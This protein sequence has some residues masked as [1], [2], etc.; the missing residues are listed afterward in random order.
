MFFHQIKPVVFPHSQPFLTHGIGQPGIYFHFMKKINLLFFLLTPVCLPAQNRFDVVIHEIMADPSPAVGLPG[1]EWV[2]LRNRSAF[3]VNLQNWRL[4]DASTLSGPMPVFSLQPDSLVIVCTASAVTAMN[5]YGRTLSVTG[6]PSLDNTGDL[7]YLRAPDGR[8]IHA[9]QYYSDWYHHDIKKDGGWTLEM[10]DP[11]NP[12]S[13]GSNWGASINPAGGTPGKYNSIQA[14]NPD[15]YA[16]KLKSAYAHDSLTILLVF[17]EPLDSTNA[18]ENIHYS[19]SE[20]LS[21]QQAQAVPPLFSQVQLKLATA[22]QKDQI[23]HITVSGLIDCRGNTISSGSSI[24]AGMPVTPQKNDLVINEILFNPGSNGYDFVE[25]Y[26][27]G[28]HII[29]LS[30]LFI[31]NRNSS[32]QVSG[33]KVFSPEPWYVF[34]GDYFAETENADRLALSYHVKYPEQIL[35][36]DAPPSFPDDQ[37]TVVILNGA[38]DIIDELN[39]R[40]DW[41]FKLIG[42]DEGVSLERIR[43]DG[44]TQD[45][46]NWHSAASTAGYATPGYRNSQ[47]RSAGNPAAKMEISPA[48]FS[49]DNDGR[50]DFAT[51]QY[52]VDEPGYVA[53]VNIYDAGGR[54]VKRL[55]R[56]GLLGITGQW[57][58]DGL[59]ENGQKLP[60]GTYVFQTE[61]FNLQGKKESFRNTIVLARK[62]H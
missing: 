10:I 56:N 61:I 54:L 11:Q 41:H 3:P 8:T 57:T 5:V 59:G 15:I 36:I 32:G 48:I 23:Y 62:L 45:P 27:N 49:P 21:V 16:P 51:L 9:L 22:M 2:E 60:L 35:E 26:N 1:N 17:D 40:R 42:N 38:G 33:A 20:G 37:G 52:T 47:Y 18:S 7:L 13:A 25:C 44:L 39:Y 46:M 4:G 28:S 43:A 31:A 14:T 34:P 30:R 12:C 50:D 55:V 29:D 19:S 24:R 58:W 53:N 6:F